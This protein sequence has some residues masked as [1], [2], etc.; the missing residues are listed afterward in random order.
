MDKKLLL[1]LANNIEHNIKEL[2]EAVEIDNISRIKNNMYTITV[3]THEMNDLLRD[4][5]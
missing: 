5:L 4:F 3:T 2:K 1:T